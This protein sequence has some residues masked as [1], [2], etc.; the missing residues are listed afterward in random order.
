MPQGKLPRE[1]VPYSAI[2]DRP[3]LRL[4]GGARMAVWTIV[5]VVI[6]LFVS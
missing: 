3:P 5:N 6:I 2:V 4:P 1:R